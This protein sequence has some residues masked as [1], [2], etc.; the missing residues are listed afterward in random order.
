MAASSSYDMKSAK[1][2]NS[3]L[4]CQFLYAV[5]ILT[6]T[7]YYEGL[8]VSLKKVWKELEKNWEAHFRLVSKTV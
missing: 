3:F 2:L 6:L 8:S 4:F 5:Q 7:E 1:K